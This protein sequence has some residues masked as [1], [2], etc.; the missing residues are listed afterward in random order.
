MCQGYPA[1]RPAAQRREL[2][3]AGKC[4]GLLWARGWG[5]A[6]LHPLLPSPLLP[7]RPL[8][9]AA[10]LAHAATEVSANVGGRWQ[11]HGGLHAPKVEA[12]VQVE[13]LALARRGAQHGGPAVHAQAAVLVQTLGGHSVPVAQGQWLR[14]PQHGQPWWGKARWGW[15][16][17]RVPP[18]HSIQVLER[19]GHSRRN[20]TEA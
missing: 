9:A 14:A 20:P 4:P 3:L 16:P 18:A 13:A 15:R 2:R 8:G 6:G 7:C 12:C 1:G 11:P 10:H 19:T 5:G 17:Q